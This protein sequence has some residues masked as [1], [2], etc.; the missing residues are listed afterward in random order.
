[1]IHDKIIPHDFNRDL[2]ASGG[3]REEGFTL[4]ELM[5]ALVLGLL[6]VA[7]VG[8]VFIANKD[9]YRT[10]E[11]LSQ[12]QDASRT[13][14]EFLARDVREAGSNPCGAA[15]VDSVLNSADDP[16]LDDNSP[17][18]GWDEVADIESDEDYEDV[19]LPGAGEE[20]RPVGGESLIRL[21]SAEDSGLALEPRTGV[22]NEANV[23]LENPTTRISPGDILMLCDVDKATVFQ[24]TNYNSSNRVVNHNTGKESPGNRTKCLNHPVPQSESGGNCSTFSPSSYLAISTNYIWYVGV[25]G[26][27]GRSLYRYGR[28]QDAASEPAEMVRGVEGMKIEYHETDAD[29]FVEAASVSD[30]D[31]VDAARITLTVRSRGLNPDDP[32][33]GAG[34]DRERLQRNFSTTI[35]IRNRL[36]G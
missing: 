27:G 13:A 11:A 1:M 10:N 14:F 26:A 33:F 23:P 7:G 24:V 22:R 32:D 35:A 21:A 30:W 17:I 12:V 5:I 4:V 19:D 18:L 6:V 31:E 8:S 15:S 29:D 9:A 2:S 34:A 28:G 25:N 36:D 20:G 3:T 16:M